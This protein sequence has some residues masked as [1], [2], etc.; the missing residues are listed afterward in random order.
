MTP[1]ALRRIETL[2]NHNSESLTPLDAIISND[3]DDAQSMDEY[4]SNGR[5]KRNSQD[6]KIPQQNRR[7]NS[8]DETSMGANTTRQSQ[9]FTSGKQKEY[10]SK[11]SSPDASKGDNNDDFD[12]RYDMNEVSDIAICVERTY[13]NPEDVGAPNPTSTT[14]QISLDQ[15][16]I[17]AFHTYPPAPEY[18]GFSNPK[19]SSYYSSKDISPQALSLEALV[20]DEITDSTISHSF[21]FSCIQACWINYLLTIMTLIFWI[22]IA[23]FLHVYYFERNS[24]FD[25]SIA[26]VSVFLGL[27]YLCYFV[28]FVCYSGFLPCCQPPRR[29]YGKCCG[30]AFRGGRFLR[31]N[32]HRAIRGD[33]VSEREMFERLKLLET[34][35]PR[36]YLTIGA[37][38]YNLSDTVDESEQ[39]IKFYSYRAERDVDITDFKMT[40]PP[41]ASFFQKIK[42]LYYPTIQ[43]ESKCVL[44]PSQTQLLVNM[45][46]HVQKLYDG[47]DMFLEVGVAYDPGDGMIVTVMP[48]LVTSPAKPISSPAQHQP[49]ALANIAKSLENAGI[50]ASWCSNTISSLLSTSETIAME[51][52]PDSRYL[53]AKTL[54]SII[55]N[56]FFLWFSMY[57]TLYLPFVMLWRG[58]HWQLKYVCVKHVIL[59]Q[60]ILPTKS[61]TFRQ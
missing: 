48:P 39:R 38:H 22:C 41:V 46:E 15:L 19:E 31:D 27:A 54:D 28:V 11:D 8:F 21:F 53:I 42:T 33:T 7:R 30:L 50:G 61:I 35:K 37:Y 17:P 10:K 18:V 55:F 32:V 43:I 5:P 45:I 25:L 26:L 58:T 36:L 51:E 29:G 44:L 16:S 49:S 23:V 34:S 56:R 12:A 20:V 59:S 60:R 4:V 24:H 13:Q 9:T 2:K 14:N 6:S 57:T 3:A 52:N 47:V 1:I 40:S